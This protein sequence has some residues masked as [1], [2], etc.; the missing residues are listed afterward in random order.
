M[1][2]WDLPVLQLTMDLI[3]Y[4]SQGKR[5]FDFRLTWK[6]VTQ[7]HAQ[8]LQQ[9]PLSPQV[10]TARVTEL[11]ESNANEQHQQQ[12]ELTNK[13]MQYITDNRLFSTETK[14]SLFPIKLP[15]K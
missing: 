10:I 13:R 7:L 8:V 1:C 5:V 9:H 12:T 4:L 6:S 3:Q 2:Y 14:L 11:Q 15:P